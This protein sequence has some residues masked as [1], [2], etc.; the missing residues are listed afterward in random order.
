MEAMMS[1]T[2]ILS[3]IRALVGGEDLI[4]PEVLKAYDS[5]SQDQFEF[6]DQMFLKDFF[7]NLVVRQI[8]DVST[9]SDLQEAIMVFITTCYIINK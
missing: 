1:F 4:S 8:P 5:V 6:A 2:Q 3:V 9:R 7:D